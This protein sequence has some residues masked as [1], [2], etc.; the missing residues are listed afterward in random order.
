MTKWFLKNIWPS[1]ETFSQLSNTSSKM[2]AWFRG[3]YRA[4]VG[5]PRRGGDAEQ[6]IELDNNSQ[7]LEEFEDNPI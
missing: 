7:P 3:K 6:A 5:Q 2:A 4:C 1:K